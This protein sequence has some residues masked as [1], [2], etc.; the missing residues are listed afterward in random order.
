ME[1]TG[2]IPASLKPLGYIDYSKQ[3]KRLH[4]FY[5]QAPGDALP[6]C[7]SWEIDAAEFM[8]LK[9]AKKTIHA[10]QLELLKRLQFI[11]NHF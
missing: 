4:C 2:V 9:Q 5:G 6:H 8:T 7:A 10:D 3:R 1:E 11:L